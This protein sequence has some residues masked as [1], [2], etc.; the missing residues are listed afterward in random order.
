MAATK[1]VSYTNWSIYQSL[2]SR[3]QLRLPTDVSEGTSPIQKAEC[4]L[5]LSGYPPEFIAFMKTKM[6]FDV[7]ESPDGKFTT[8]V[9]TPSGDPKTV[10]VKLGEKIEDKD[11]LMGRP[12]SVSNFHRIGYTLK[13]K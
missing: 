13:R 2:S 3:T 5:Y 11:P 9:S 10:V 6:T 1:L 12:Y 8:I 7:T 4:H